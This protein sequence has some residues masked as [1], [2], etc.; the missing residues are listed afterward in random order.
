[1]EESLRRTDMNIILILVL[2]TW[3]LTPPWV[4]IVATI[5]LS[6]LML[7]DTDSDD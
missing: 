5:I 6:F 4:N 1:M 7:V 2:W 3:G